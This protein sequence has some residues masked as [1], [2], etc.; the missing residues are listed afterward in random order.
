MAAAPHPL[1]DHL[2]ALAAHM[3]WADGAWF[4]A[5][6][7]GGLQDDPDLLQRT[8]HCADVQAAFLMVLRGDPVVFPADP[9]PPEFRALRAQ[10]RDNHRGFAGLFE[11]LEPGDLARPVLL[12]WFPG[13]PCRVSVADALTQVAM[14]TQHHRGQM[15]TRLRDLGG[16][17]WNVDFIIWTWKDRPAAQWE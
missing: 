17:P 1:F 8:R 5:W 10:A 15:M 14:H 13:P 4:S 9:P 3:A 12:P 16:R 2:R 7:E 11:T 6:A